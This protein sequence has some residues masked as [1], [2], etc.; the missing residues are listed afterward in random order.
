MTWVHVKNFAIS[1][2]VQGNSFQKKIALLFGIGH[3]VEV[4]TI[5]S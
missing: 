5:L 3:V 2:Q 4:N 1:V